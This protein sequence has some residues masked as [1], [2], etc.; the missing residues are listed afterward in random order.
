MKIISVD[1]HIVEH[2]NV[3]VDRLPREYRDAGPRVISED[4]SDFWLYEGRKTV[5]ATGISAASGRDKQDWSRDGLSFSEMVLGCH[6]PRARLADMDTDGV[7]A[8]LCFPTFPRFAGVRFLRGDDKKLALLCVQ[9]Y[10]DFI[11]DE[12]CSTNRDR[13]IPLG[14]L[15]LWDMSLALKEL[16]RVLALGFKSISFPEL[17]EPLGLPTWHSGH[18]DPL[19]S[20]VADAGVPLSVHIGT[21]QF[22]MPVSTDAPG[23][24]ADGLAA[25]SLA[26][27][28]APMMAMVA[29]MTFSHVFHRFPSL[30]I[31]LSEGGI[32][33]APYLMERLD[34]VWDKQRLWAGLPESDLLPSELIRRHFYGCFIDDLFGLANRHAVG[35]DN[36]MIESDYPHSDSTWPLTRSTLVELMKDVPDDEVHKMVELNA[37][38][39]YNFPDSEAG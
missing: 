9:A 11:I 31:A 22:R 3:W 15:P 38:R 39:L 33:W 32:G 10:N 17:L 21:S 19:F 28:A 5:Y 27:L 26:L 16:E 36:I 4:G 14:V 8:Q 30:R 29:D 25:A 37:R 2:P 24:S 13:Y 1:D 6:D 23:I 34:Q 20:A 35:V 18:W 7:W 12:W